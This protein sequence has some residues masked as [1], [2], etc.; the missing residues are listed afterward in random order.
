MNLNNQTTSLKARFVEMFG[1]PT[2][3]PKGYPVKVLSQIAECWNGLTYKP[4]DV[5]D[6]GIIVLRSSNIQ[7]ATLD[8]ADI[9]ISTST[10]RRHILIC[11]YSPLIE[12]IIRCVMYCFSTFA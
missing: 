3:N 9:V 11:N 8:F 7:N 5:S 4:E 2:T 10:H 6:E 12:K 1:D